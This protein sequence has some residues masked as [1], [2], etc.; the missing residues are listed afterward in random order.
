[1]L[2]PWFED[3]QTAQMTPKKLL[4]VMA[5]LF[6]LAGLAALAFG[7]VRYF[8][9]EPLADYGVMAIGGIFWLLCSAVALFLRAR[10][11]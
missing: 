6:L 11:P 2:L 1:M 10:L 8:G 7:A 4:Q 3:R 9:G 5:G